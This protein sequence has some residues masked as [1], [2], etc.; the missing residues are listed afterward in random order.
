MSLRTIL[1]MVSGGDGDTA[2]L[3]VAAAVA[4]RFSAHIDVLH[5]KGDPRDAVPFLGEGASGALI[6]QIMAAAQ[7][8]AEGR[9]GRARANFDSWRQGAGLP[10]VAHAGGAGPS[11]QWSEE[12][13]P[14]DEW[15]GRRGRLSDMIVLA[16]P[17]ANGSVSSTIAFEA[18]LLDTGRPVLT[19]PA[20]QGAGAKIAS[21]PTVVAWNGSI[22]AARAILAAMPFIAASPAV[23][24]MVVSEGSAV[25]DA[26]ALIRYLAR[27]G[28]KAE[29][30]TSQS[31]T[32]AVGAEFLEEAGRIS[33]GLL[34]MG[35]YTHSRVRQMVFGGVTKHV[36]ANAKLPVLFAH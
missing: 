5:V 16:Q 15:I 14:E 32:M 7:R 33:A 12:V 27:H 10:V 24:V 17:G 8:D 9:S 29:A 25:A 13:G 34:V 22:E 1:A 20:M 28:V 4:R 23:L 36:L 2:T 11:V 30:K 3:D 21:A 35:G 19:A 6:E 31:K 26:E 18:A